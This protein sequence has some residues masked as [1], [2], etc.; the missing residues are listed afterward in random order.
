MAIR[1]MRMESIKKLRERFGKTYNLY[2]GTEI[3]VEIALLINH[4]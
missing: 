3:V 2:D 4:L 1:T